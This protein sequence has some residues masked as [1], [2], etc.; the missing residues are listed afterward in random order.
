MHRE[1][2]SQEARQAAPMWR[3]LGDSWSWK[4]R[5]F[6]VKPE[7]KLAKEFVLGL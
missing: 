1:A 6:R 3:G 2:P 4:I 5:G 7:P